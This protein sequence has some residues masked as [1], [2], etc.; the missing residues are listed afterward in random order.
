MP[1]LH[2]CGGLQSSGSTLVSWCFLQRADMNG[3][4]DADNDMLPC[5]DPRGRADLLWSKT[6][7]S[8]FR[9]SE[10]IEHCQDFGWRVRP[11]LIVRDVR[12]VWASL[13]EKPYG[14]NGVTAEDPPL[15]LR[16]RRFLA[17]WELFRD[18]G[19]PILRYENLLA[20]PEATLRR[21][22]YDL[23]LAWDEGMLCWPKAPDDIADTEHGN[24][25]FW[26]TR[27]RDLSETIASHAEDFKPHAVAAD[28]WAWLEEV[29]GAFNAAH[30]YPLAMEVPETGQSRPPRAI[31]G[32][33]GTRRSKW[34]LRS[35][36]I[37]WFLSAV[38]IP[39]PTAIDQK[40]RR[41]AA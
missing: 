13:V 16:F 22:C 25:T 32:F 38:G 2:L 24:R 8:G 17:D 20:E 1:T 15:R 11:L 37:R 33:D 40:A 5:F 12:K 19:W 29:F 6:T 3:V 27:G 26:A 23:G 39:S 21:A 41:K 34:E 30:H 10:I 36:P 18:R 14:V 28:D 35:R 31:P 4:L 9:L 7:I